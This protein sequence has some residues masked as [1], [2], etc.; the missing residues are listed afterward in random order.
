MDLN[1]S[2]EHNLVEETNHFESNFYDNFT[3]SGTLRIG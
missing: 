1:W 3:F 2:R